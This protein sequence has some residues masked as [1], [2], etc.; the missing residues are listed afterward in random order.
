MCLY[1]SCIIVPYANGYLARKDTVKIAT[2]TT[3]G[4]DKNEHR[5]FCVGLSG[6]LHGKPLSTCR[7]LT[8]SN[9][10]GKHVP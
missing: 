3:C 10:P 5:W 1:T 9:Y 7:V 2:N 8:F 4:N 6:F